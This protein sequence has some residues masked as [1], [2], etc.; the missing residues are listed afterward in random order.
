MVGLGTAV[1][2]QV[3]VVHT[4]L[5]RLLFGTTSLSAFDW[6]LIVLVSSSI[7]VVDELMKLFGVHGS[8]AQSTRPQGATNTG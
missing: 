7:W 6:L 1:A 8:R 4:G 2:L 3:L 5:G